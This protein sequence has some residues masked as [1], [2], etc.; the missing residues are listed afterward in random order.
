MIDLTQVVTA[1]IGLLIVAVSTVLIPYLK[2]K[3]NAEQMAQ[4]EFWVDVAVRAAEMIYIGSGRGAEKKEYVIKFLNS[5]GFTI[6][7]DSI[8]AMV[9]AA[10]LQLKM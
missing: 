6:D 7:M 9:E 2:Q 3:Y 8:D 5:K 10:V 4:I 1:L